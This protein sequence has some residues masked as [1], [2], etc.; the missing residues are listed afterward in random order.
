MTA[1]RVLICDDSSMARRLMARALPG[2][3]DVNVR[4]AANGEEAVAALARETID[5]LFLDL[6]MPV[7]DGYAVLEWIR[8]RGI[9]VTPF[10]VSGDIQPDAY[11][12]V[13]ALGAEAFLRKPVDPGILRDQLAQSD[14][15]GGTGSAPG[16]EAAGDGPAV[17]FHEVC[18][19]VAN[20]AMG[21]AADQLARLLGVFIVMPV[22]TVN[23]LEVSELRMALAAAE[24]SDSITAVCQG[25]VGS[26]IAGEAMLLFHDSGFA[27]IAGL[28]NY[29]GEIDSAIELELVMDTANV[30]IGAFLGGFADQLDLGFSQSHPTILGRH[31]RIGELLDGGPSRL[32]RTL[33]I[34]I[35]YTV[36]QH[37]I[38]CDLLL[39]IPDDSV[40]ALRDKLA[41]LY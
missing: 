38:S 30:L 36:E 22:P 27:D 29:T 18:R 4:F 23:D 31:T 19:E 40:P 35:N 26:G 8:D 37:A 33:A 34:E 12:K 28:M 25:F 11:R 13:L 6:T 10:V 15:F 39:L 20:V 41:Y 17:A 9:P 24:G 5:V 14:L 32:Q 3:W 16:H 21:R 2:D 7:M 1:G